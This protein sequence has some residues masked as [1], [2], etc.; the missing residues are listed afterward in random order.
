MSDGGETISR[1][2][3]AFR[4]AEAR[5]AAWQ[6]GETLYLSIL[7]L[8]RIPDSIHALTALQ[9]LSLRITQVSDLAPLAG[10][11][12][13]QSLDCSHCRITAVPDGLFDRPTLEMVFCY[14]GT[15]ADIPVEVLSQEMFDNCLPRIR[16]HLRD[17]EAG[18]ERMR[19]AKMLVLGNG[20]VGK[21]QLCR[22]LLGEQFED[23]AA[24]THAITVRP[25]DQTAPDG[26]PFR[27][28]LWDFGGQDIYHS[29]HTLFMRSRGLYLVAWTPEQ[30]DNDTHTWK[31]HTFR[32]HTLP[33]WLAQ[34]ADFGGQKAPLMVVQ[35]Q[36]DTARDRRPLTPA[37]R[38]KAEAFETWF[39]LDYSA[40]T[41]RRHASLMDTIKD[42]YGTLEQP[43]VGVVRAKVKRVLEDLMSD[44]ARR[45]MT[46]ADF[47]DLCAK[48]GGVADPALFL[49]TL[50]NAGT[51]FYRAGFFG[52]KII[53]DQEWA[54]RAIYA[55][56]ERDS[57]TYT[58]IRR[59]GGHFT[60][61]LLGQTLWDADY[62]TKDEQDLFL[63]MM[64]SCGI[65]FENRP[66][67]DDA[68]LEADYIAPDLLPE[69][70]PGHHWDG[71]GAEQKQGRHYTHLPGALI[72]GVICAIGQKAGTQ[73]DYWRHGVQFTDART[74]SEGLISSD[75]TG[76]T[77]TLST[78]LG[79]SA[80]LLATLIEIVI[81]EENRLGL[82]PTQVTGGPPQRTRHADT[83]ADPANP[84][85]RLAPKR[86]PRAEPEWYFS[87]ARTSEEANDTPVAKFC[88]AVAQKT[89]I[90]VRRDVNELGYGDS[91]EAFMRQ[92]AA[93]ERIFVWLTDDYLK[94]PY[95]MSE[96][97]E[98]WAE[99]IRRGKQP[100]ASRD[101]FDTRVR[102]ILDGV[103]IRNA[104]D[105]KV[106]R[107]Y[108][109]NQLAA[110]NEEFQGAAQTGEL[111]WKEKNAIGRFCENTGEILR[112]IGSRIRYPSFEAFEAAELESR[113][114]VRECGILRP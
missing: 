73:G 108:W 93:G 62:Y 34:V 17:L 74:K 77:L 21:T 71:E 48:Q 6:P 2:E 54:I 82:T 9:S 64:R 80:A 89:G 86:P 67:D 25:F 31:G 46:M 57:S 96:L 26:T 72:R 47:R 112:Y 41:K 94:S 42:G 99:S 107:D 97:H 104:T 101:D 61:C 36:A 79:D 114:A 91:I 35:T 43:I 75:A 49:E 27:I 98:I 81:R 100:D 44:Q 22:R 106:Y 55:V 92:L 84:V 59:Q 60:R 76:G 5:I 110:I 19:D 30:E 18:A 28:Q 15:L 13:L 68:G 52:D 70:L 90:T 20:R 3:E 4:E 88:E 102:V 8:N 105:I 95:C 56:F 10:L 66:G 37:A 29:T 24:S 7:G 50:H 38:E 53:L 16:A 87:Y 103:T 40:R 32:N 12:H 11:T 58:I 45:A 83:P 33:Y 111:T 78:R 65:C 113:A 1:A 109:T 63:S 39:D 14:Q 51:L 85:E 69:R 23:N